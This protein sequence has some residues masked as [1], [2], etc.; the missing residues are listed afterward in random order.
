MPVY[1]DH[2][3]TTP[4]DPRVLEAMMPYLRDHHGNASSVHSYGRLARNAVDQAREQ[5][6]ALVNAQSTQVVFT[7]CGTEANNLALKGVAAR[8]AVGRVAVSAVEH[9]SLL[10]PA[11]ALERQGWIIDTIAVDD[12]CRVS[13]ASLSEALEDASS[14]VIKAAPQ[15]VSVMMANNE[16]GAIQDIPAISAQARRVGAIM[17]TDAVQAAGKIPVDFPA[18]GAH[19]MSLSAH[20]L[21]GPKGVGALIVDKSLELEPLLHGGGHEMGRR[22]GTENVAGIVGFGAAAELTLNELAVRSAHLRKLRDLLE[23]GLR[24]LPGAVIFAE[25][26]ERLPN[27]V[28]IGVPGID[29]EALLMNLDRKG[30]AVSSGS[31]CASGSGEPSH[32]LLAMGVD[33][34]LARRVIRISLG[35]GNTPEDVL[36]LIA[37]LCEQIDYLQAHT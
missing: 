11:R 12:Q 19:L 15:I 35:Q 2:N 3:A 17:H 33:F 23:A 10:G 16:T 31:A 20:K 27:T 32:V 9:A 37:A 8:L 7:G 4:L 22:G 29:G 26:A 30:I 24:E 25:C 18:S 36:R 34:E 21:Y 13:M 28:L 5:V 6:A 14:D 1:L